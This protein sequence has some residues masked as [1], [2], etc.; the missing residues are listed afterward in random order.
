MA[1]LIKSPLSPQEQ[2]Q[3]DDA[4]MK[5]VMNA[6][7]TSMMMIVSMMV[8][9]PM[10][11]KSFGSRLGIGQAQT[12]AYRGRTD[13]RE[14]QAIPTLKWIDLIA[15]PPYT[16]WVLCFIINDGPGAVEIAINQPNDRF[17]MASG[18]TRTI[19]RTGAEEKISSLFYVAEPGFTALL[20][21]TGEY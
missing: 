18:E 4:F 19:N 5:D 13:S 8:F 12:L 3:K 15:D 14:L 9:L 20:R 6:M 10:I 1:K 21:I 17:I 2:K 11:I 16:P 7:S